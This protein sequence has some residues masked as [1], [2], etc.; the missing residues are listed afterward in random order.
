MEMTKIVNFSINVVT[1]IEPA[2][3]ELREV[4]TIL[5]VFKSLNIKS[6]TLFLLIAKFV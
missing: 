6:N 3:I 5:F 2:S 4:H 1:I